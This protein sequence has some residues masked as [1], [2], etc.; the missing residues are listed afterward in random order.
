MSQELHN[1]NSTADGI[2]NSSP[3]LDEVVRPRVIAS[4]WLGPISIYLEIW[5]LR[6]GGPHGYAQIWCNHIG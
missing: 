5:K 3:D 6:D 4:D 2:R 1:I